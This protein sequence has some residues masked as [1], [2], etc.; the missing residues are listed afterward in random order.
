MSQSQ[1]NDFQ[2]YFQILRGRVWGF[3]FKL[4]SYIFLQMACIYLLK[5]RECPQSLDFVITTFSYSLPGRTLLE[6]LLLEI[7]NVCIITQVRI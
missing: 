3:S 7:E 6:V 5:S 4:G 1:K 2:L